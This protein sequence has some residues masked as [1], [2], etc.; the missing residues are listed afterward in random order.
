MDQHDYHPKPYKIGTVGDKDQSDGGD[1]VDDLFLKVLAWEERLCVSLT[2]TWQ[3]LFLDAA[4]S[5][6]HVKHLHKV[7][8]LP[9]ML[10]LSEVLHG[11]RKNEHLYA[12]FMET[13]II[14]VKYT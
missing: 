5:Q 10:Q 4:A 7:S 2:L 14:P 3:H 12:Q 1:V 6:G 13:Q 11:P 9:T 8:V